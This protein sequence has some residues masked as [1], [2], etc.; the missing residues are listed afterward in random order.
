MRAAPPTPVGPTP[1]VPAPA[2]PSTAPP[3]GPS[4]APPAGTPPSGPEP[5]TPLASRLA[6]LRALVPGLAAIQ[7]PS[8]ATAGKGKEPAPPAC[9]PT[10][11]AERTKVTEDLTEALA[12][13]VGGVAALD[14]AQVLGLDA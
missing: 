5:V 3:V 12:T 8:S 4:A 11:E 6:G 1:L 14:V 10:G 9:L 2:D 7:G 13:V